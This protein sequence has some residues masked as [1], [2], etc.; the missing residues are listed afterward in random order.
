MDKKRPYIVTGFSLSR[1][2]MEWLEKEAAKA[3]RSKSNMLDLLLH[4]L[5]KD[6]GK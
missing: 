6:R 5:R 1:E 2:N 3:K 4:A